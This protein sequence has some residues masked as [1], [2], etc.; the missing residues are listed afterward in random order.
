MTPSRSQEVTIITRV[1]DRSD[2]AIQEALKKVYSQWA[3]F[4]VERVDWLT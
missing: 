3:N 1:R 2:E 4:K